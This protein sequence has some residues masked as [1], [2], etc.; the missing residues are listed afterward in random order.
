MKGG[1]KYIILT[2]F[3]FGILNADTFKVKINDEVKLIPAFREARAL[4][5]ASGFA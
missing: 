4:Y 1:L 2:L 5:I 3:I